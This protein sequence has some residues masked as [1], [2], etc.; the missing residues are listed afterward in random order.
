MAPWGAA[1]PRLETTA[2]GFAYNGS[3]RTMLQAFNDD[4]CIFVACLETIRSCSIAVFFLKV[5]KRVSWWSFRVSTTFSL[6]C[7][8]LL[9]DFHKK[10]R[11]RPSILNYLN[12]TFTFG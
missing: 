2:L 7:L 4:S 6:L 3:N 9:T 1:A 10:A 12:T 11:F 5:F 8:I